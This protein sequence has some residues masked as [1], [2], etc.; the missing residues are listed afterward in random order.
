[1]DV[2]VARQPIFT[3][4]RQVFG[5]ELLFRLGLENAFPDIDGDTATSGVLSNTFFSFEVNEI[6]GEK[7]GLIN[8]TKEL[9]L[10]KTP[11]LFS[12]KHVIVEVLE[13]IEPDDEIITALS[14]IRDS[15]FKLALDDFIFHKKFEPMMALCRIIKFDLIATPLETLGNIVAD[16]SK[17]Y[18]II[19]LA[20]KVETY[21][22]FEL[23]KQ[24]GF[25]LFQG[26]FFSKPEILS[27][28]EVSS[29]KINVLS[30]IS[31][32]GK[33][34]LNFTRIEYLIKRDV[35]ISFKLLK[36]I[37]SPYFARLNPINTIKDAITFLGVTELR[38]FIN[39]AAAS[40]LNDEKPDELLRLSIIRARMCE[41]CGQVIKTSFSPEELFTLGLF[42]SM[43]AM[44]DRKMEDIMDSIMLSDRIKNALTGKNREFKN[45][46]AIVISFEQG[47][48][49]DKIY[50]VIAG[51]KLEKKLPE[52]YM[53]SIRMA[54]SM[55][56]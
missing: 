13:D 31:E 21:E 36:F 12:P 47:R 25:T 55:A 44:L 39:V 28:K 19:L 8:F 54:D 32:A 29:N 35:S 40:A 48:W 2:F 6:L 50:A 45:L 17:N 52:F 1:M 22:E 3:V 11:L 4:S 34:D 7:P 38:K 16:I 15:G 5:Y 41:M 49:T 14:D 9:I 56:I 27:K 18:D 53:D 30:L 26:Y 20:E 24:M 10:Q 46:L 42:S 43:D 23:A 33:K 51:T 37:N